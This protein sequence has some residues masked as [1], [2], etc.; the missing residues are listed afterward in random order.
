M[1]GG[2]AIPNRFAPYNDDAPESAHI[3]WTKPFTIGGVAGGELGDHAFECGDA[4]EGKFPGPLII[5]G[6]LYY[7]AGGSR[8]L[9]PVIY[10]C[11]DLHT[12]EEL[13]A[14][15]L[16]D[17]R[18]IAFGQLFYWDSFNYHG[19]F[20]YLWVTT[21][22][23]TWFG[24]PTPENWY[25]FDAFTG[26]WRYTIENVP[27]GTILRGSKGEIYRLNVNLR[28]GWMALWDSSKLVNPQNT[29]GPDDGSW[30][31]VAHGRTF[32]AAA[33]TTAAQIAW[34][35][36]K[37]IPTDLSGSVQVAELDDRVVG[38]I[39]TP[40]KVE[41][42]SLSLEPG[43]EGRELFRETWNAPSEWTTGN[44][45]VGWAG[46]SLKEG[47]LVAWVKETRQ[48]YGFSTTTGKFLWKTEP[49]HYLNFH[50][51][52][53]TAIVYG[54]LYSSGVS[55]IVYCYDLKT[56]NR[57][58]TYLADDPYQEILWTNNWWGQI[59]FI[60][61]GKIY[62]G[63]SEHSPIDPKPRGAP[64]TCL[65][66]TT[67][68]EI[69]RIDGAFRQT[70]WGGTAIIG[71]SIIATQ[72]SYDQRVYAIGK[73]PSA[74]TVT[75]SPEI[76]VH[77]SS[78]MLRGTVTDISSGTEDYALRARFPNGVP[79]VSDESM[80]DWMLHVYKQFPKPAATGVL[81]TL[82]A[83]D[84]NYN[85]QNLGTVTTD[86]YGN[87]GFTFEPEVP[88]QYMIIATFYGSDAYY[89]S[90]TT[91]YLSVDPAPSPASPI[92]AEESAAPFISTEVAIIAVVAVA[93]VIGIAAYW[94][95]RKRK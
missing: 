57:L 51:A 42:W 47:V 22:G 20:P 7:T 84:P 15:T 34:I 46:S 58:W 80:S 4:Y 30:G 94:T 9:E 95:L 53:E 67:G 86:V 66:A 72:D 35:W 37:T 38:G 56:G 8:G 68:E 33:D 41:S 12:G 62:L 81:V 74:T 2:A 93:A 79:A 43:K 44:L 55:G 88:G 32:D 3:L 52:T 59:V 29:G 73:G 28:D 24:P 83:V 6:K 26:D 21:G 90:T 92:E 63:H 14:K 85:Y 31:N 82:E 75:A 1:F 27:S 76:S 48:Y 39:V 17:N 16:L 78:V 89:A 18:T 40:T 70:H 61:D 77:G 50:V 19:V 60:T 36:N 91:T 71:D 10:R 54:K 65:N 49:Q 11:V 45:T 87:Y 23:F 25:A 13:W 69:F 64:F 5:A